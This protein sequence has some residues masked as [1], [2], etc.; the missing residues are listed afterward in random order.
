MA[1]AG[2]NRMML[3]TD[4]EGRQIE[5]LWRVGRLVRPEGRTAW[6]EAI[7]LDGEPLMLSITETLNDDEEL[8]GRFRAAGEIRHPNVVRIEEARTA[9]IDDSP[10][11]IAA[12]EVTE[13]NLGDV[14]RERR[15]TSI[16][17]QA[18]LEAL[19]QGLAAI[20]A[21]GL[22]HGRMESASVLAIGDAIKLR[23]D[24]LYEGESGFAA[25]A[26]ENVRRA[27]QIVTQAMTG[28]TPAGEND[29]V[30]QLLA[31]PMA[32]AVRRAL[33]GTARIEEIAALC[34]IRLVPAKGREESEFRKPTASVPLT[35]SGPI[36]DLPKPVLVPALTSTSPEKQDDG[37]AATKAVPE[38]AFRV[39]EKT[40]LCD[41][42]IAS[43]SVA[44][45]MSPKR[46]IAT[47]ADGSG[48]VTPKAS[49]PV[50]EPLP[51][52]LLPL[53]EEED[54]PRRS[55]LPGAPWVVG[56]AAL[57][58][59]ATV[60][61]LFG[62]IH[63]A[64]SAKP[65]PTPVAALTHPPAATAPHAA[66]APARPANAVVLSSPGWRVVA[67]TYNH[68]GQAEHKAQI[69]AQRYPQFSPGVFSVHGRAPYLVTLGGVMSRSDAQTL[70]ERAVRMGLPRDTYAQ[71]YH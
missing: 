52:H 35:V 6:F 9:H 11:A 17:A 33:S 69:L 32:R 68:E 2:V 30:L 13:E 66:I 67:F 60:W 40:A 14:L 59:L 53:L 21:R 46:D 20:H 57:I 29:P 15:L 54:V 4:L 19:V 10:V 38:S 22:L 39:S 61:S 3:W 5:G 71:N 31:E 56:V 28:R 55:L 18:V 43:T 36:P 12:M 37:S 24:C 62:L 58:V 7:A 16:E 44:D 45:L 23:S 26:A 50:Q 51:P 63:R 25:A 8:V 49:E 70:R 27:G 42:A 1:T 34:G 47:L 48:L 65:A 64:R 41:R